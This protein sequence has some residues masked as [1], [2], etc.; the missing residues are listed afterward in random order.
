MKKECGF[1]IIEMAFVLV[2]I[3]FI[4]TGIFGASKII[5]NSKANESITIVTDLR[6]AV[7][8]FKNQYSYLPGDWVYSANEIPNTIAGGNGNGLINAAESV[9]AMSQLFNAG[10]IRTPTPR[11]AYGPI[12]IISTAESQVSAVGFN[13][14]VRNVIVL[15][16]IPCD[17][18]RMI[19]LKLDDGDLT[20]GNAR[21]SQAICTAG[22]VNDPMPFYGFSID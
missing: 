12:T 10:F 13:P 14:S 2:I 21:T 20:Q 16:N 15:Q 6:N 11:T 1:T 4:L 3:G 9:N 7:A 5:E 22:A 8:A 18:V 19:D 17:V